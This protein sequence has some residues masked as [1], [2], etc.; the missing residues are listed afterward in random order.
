[1]LKMYKALMPFFGGK[2]KLANRI[3]KYAEGETFIDGFLGGGSV[4]LLAK[5]KGFRVISNDMAERSAVLG[6]ALIVNDDVY[7]EDADI[8]RLYK[9]NPSNNHFIRDNHPKQYTIEL[10]DFLDNARANIDE[11]NDPI[12]K[13]LMLYLLIR[14]LTFYRPQA[15]FSHINAVEYMNSDSDDVTDT[16]Q[17]LRERYSR[18]LYDV[19]KELAKE[20]NGGIFSNGYDNE[21]YRKDIFEFLK[22]VSGDT[23]YLD[24]PYYGAESYEQHYKVLDSVVAGKKFDS[25]KHSV[26]NSKQVITTTAQLFESCSHI[27]VL[28]LSVGRRII[29]KEKYIDLLKEFRKEVIDIPVDHSHSYGSGDA[30]ETGKQEVLL[31]GRV[32]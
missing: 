9:E 17:G 11:I 30:V 16:I 3:L 10:T 26:F 5:A 1:M 13:S 4:S 24:P 25:V 2:R 21:I 28:I 14:I 19:I 20:I 6:H 31:V 22:H 7:I 29:D 27:P 15:S 32:A 18:P 23:V 8:V 12:K